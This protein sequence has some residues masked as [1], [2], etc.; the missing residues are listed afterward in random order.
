VDD[1][2][3]DANSMERLQVLSK[4]L[5]S[6]AEKGGFKFKETLM[7]GDPAAMLDEPRKVLGLVRNSRRLL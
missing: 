4:E 3:A 2:T 1:A 6:V 5:E 7:S